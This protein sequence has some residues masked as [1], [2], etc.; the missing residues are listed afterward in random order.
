MQQKL[1]YVILGLFLLGVYYSDSVTARN[2]SASPSREALLGCYEN[3]EVML[4]EF[5]ERRDE[6]H[7]ATFVG[8]MKEGDDEEYLT[9]WRKKITDSPRAIEYRLYFRRETCPDRKDAFL[10]FVQQYWP[11]YIPAE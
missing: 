2:Q 5:K 9:K 4:G 6:L 1:C 11:M 7:E 3:N 10:Y 8:T